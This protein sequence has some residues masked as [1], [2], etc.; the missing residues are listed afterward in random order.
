MNR[1]YI[2]IALSCLL[3]ACGGT[4]EDDPDDPL[5]ASPTPT[6]T[7]AP[8]ST[9]FLDFWKTELESVN[10][11]AQNRFLEDGGAVVNQPEVAA[12]PAPAPTD[13]SEDD[14]SS[15]NVQVAGVDEMD[16]LKFDGDVLLNLNT[17]SSFYFYEDQASQA[18]QPMV[19][20]FNE[21]VLEGN[22]A[23]DPNLHLQL[24]NGNYYRGLLTHNG[25]A[26]LVG[27]EQG[28]YYPYPE[29]AIDIGFVS[30]S[31]CYRCAPAQNLTIVLD[32]WQYKNN[33]EAIAPEPKKVSIDGS[34]ITAR[35]IDNKVYLLSSYSPQI[36]GFDYYPISQEA[37]DNNQR[38]I[39]G[40]SSEDL[41]PKITINGES[42]ALLEENSCALPSDYKPLGYLP[43]LYI[44]TSIDMEDPSKRESLC[45]VKHVQESYFGRENIYLLS[46]KYDP[47][48]YQ[49]SGV[50]IQK[51]SITDQG[52]ELAGTGMV[53]GS[54]S[55]DG[56]QL[57]EV[58][59]K[60][61]IVNTIYHYHT[62][63]NRDLLPFMAEAGFYHQLTLLEETE[64]GLQIS[65]Q[66]PNETR[67][68]S[69]GKPGEQIYAVRFMK[70]RAYVVT[71][72]KVDPL[73]VIDLSDTTDPKILGELEIPGFSDY[74]HVINDDLLFGI[75][76]NAVNDG[77][78]TWFQGLNIRLFDVSDPSQPTAIVDKD[79]GLRGSNSALLSDP[80]A[81][82]YTLNESTG[83]ARLAFPVQLHDSEEAVNPEAPLNQYYDW[84]ESSLLQIEID[85]AAK[86][87]E[88][89]GRYVYATPDST[90]SSNGFD[91]Y[92]S[93]GERS[94]INNNSLYFTHNSDLKVLEWGSGEVIRSFPL[95]NSTAAAD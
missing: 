2:G 91:W 56:Y 64:S 71:F 5:A 34:L 79:Y 69:I 93:W 25:H 22:L 65:G 30:T 41:S 50:E 87:M 37:I 26:T 29:P 57:A 7:P 89:V 60:F 13:S 62:Q 74:I 92:W 17:T 73:Y 94:I 21:D 11:N 9:A 33:Q 23:E 27:Q 52:M 63:N 38:I 81:L 82:A 18:V 19:R 49:T 54:L 10:K 90:G 53:S 61:A 70:Q 80:H 44:V 14:F 6:P 46:N 75:G 59:G 15:T 76:K 16:A 8:E 40:L 3:S 51:I 36:T 24:E 66:I 78:T 95:E 1:Y 42:S 43:S 55:G 68:T 85:T 32:M 86:T 31:L 67:N 20:V 47:S 84:K 28:L 45:L 58:D 88:E 4:N 12:T 72:D 83:I 39:D 35:S 48:N 77:R